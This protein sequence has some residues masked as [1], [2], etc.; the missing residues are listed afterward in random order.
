MVPG[1][2]DQ[3]IVARDYPHLVLLVPVDR[4]LFPQLAEIGVGV[5]NDVRA[6]EVIVDSSN[7]HAPS[8]H[9]GCETG[10]LL[11]KTSAHSGRRLPTVSVRPQARTSYQVFSRRS[12]W[13][14]TCILRLIRQHEKPGKIPS[15]L[16]DSAESGARD[17]R[18]GHAD[19]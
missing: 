12:N 10:W 4:V 8:L 17:R 6:K 14:C 5:G 11:W 18:L 7:H 16:H 13:L 19:A 3:V 9:E 1:E 2:P 15:L